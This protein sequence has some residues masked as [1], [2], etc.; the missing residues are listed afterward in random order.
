MEA[1]FTKDYELLWALLLALALF[2]PVRQIIWVLYLRRDRKQGEIAEEAR[3][4]LKLRA[5]AT[6]ALLCF[7]FAYLYTS[8]LFQGRP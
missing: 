1:L 4:R 2:L 5:G 3:Q 7:V 8:H 6:A